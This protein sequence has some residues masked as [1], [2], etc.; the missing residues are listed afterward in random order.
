MKDITKE[1][2]DTLKELTLRVET[3]RCLSD[4]A[5]LAVILKRDMYWLWT[6]HYLER[7]EETMDRKLIVESLGFDPYD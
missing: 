2:A 6:H 5:Y 3:T 4:P 1:Q 7:L